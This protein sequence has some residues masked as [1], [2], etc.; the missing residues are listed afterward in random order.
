MNSQTINKELSS[1]D[2]SYPKSTPNIIAILNI[3]ISTG[4]TMKESKN[5]YFVFIDITNQTY[6]VKN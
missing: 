4:N 6:L 5:K 3:V 2:N 1:F